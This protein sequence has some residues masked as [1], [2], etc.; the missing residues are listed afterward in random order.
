MDE[1]LRS[2]VSSAKQGLHLYAGS[3]LGVDLSPLMGSSPS[4]GWRSNEEDTP[5]GQ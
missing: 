3:Y 5:P 2:L 1:K 4:W